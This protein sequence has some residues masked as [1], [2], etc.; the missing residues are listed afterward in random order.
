MHPVTPLLCLALLSGSGAFLEGQQ[1]S[2]IVVLVRDRASLDP[3]AAARIT[4]TLPAGG[5]TSA[6]TDTSG[7]HAFR[8][9]RPGAYTIKAT[10]KELVSH[11]ATIQLADREEV[12]VEFTVGPLGPEPTRLP[13]LT[14]A[15]PSPHRPFM[16][17]FDERR[18]LGIGQFLTREDLEARSGASL[19]EL[20]RPLRG[21]RVSCRGATCIPYIQRAPAGCAPIFVLDDSEV[22]PVLAARLRADDIEGIEVYAGLSQVPLELV[23]D[24]RQVRCGAIVVWTRR[25]GLKPPRP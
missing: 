22:E 11:P 20:L 12:E 3:L 19:G 1:R 23:G 18:A 24:R 10:W 13:E 4:L 6:V 8:R 5:D 17:Q 9:L 2:S 7:R 14:V 21:I 16:L 25:P 15:A